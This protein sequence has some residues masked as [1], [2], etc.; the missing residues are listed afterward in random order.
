MGCV[1][2][3][4][5]SPM[6]FNDLWCL[7]NENVHTLSLGAARPSDF[8]EHLKSMPYLGDDAKRAETIGA[9][10]ARLSEEMER[11]LGREWTKGW[12]VGL[13][14]YT[15]VPGEINVFEILRL[16]NLAR[17]YDMVEYGKMRYNLLGKGD[18]WFGGNKAE[19]LRD[20]GAALAD[21]PVAGAIPEALAKAH[22]ILSGEEVKRLG[23]H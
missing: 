13:P 6:L 2:D 15:D 8:D 1:F 10:E 17:A 19:K 14:W 18:H 4:P 3:H 20:M 21:C 16:G 22:K 11:V 7:S 9:I 5:L 12:N 23:S